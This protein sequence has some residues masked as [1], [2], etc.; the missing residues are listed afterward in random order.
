MIDRYTRAVLTVMCLC[1][2]VLTVSTLLPTAQ[3]QS[4]AQPQPAVQAQAQS[5]SPKKRCAW[6]SVQILVN[7]W[8]NKDA[9]VDRNGD[10]VGKKFQSLSE[11]GWELKAYGST[12]TTL[13][14]S[15]GTNAV[16]Y[17]FERCE[18]R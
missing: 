11:G 8:D 12:A 6:T 15:G 1:L 17:V 18:D 16:Q 13:G 14:G 9:T 3:A 5:T 2:V 4:A 7:K 10:L